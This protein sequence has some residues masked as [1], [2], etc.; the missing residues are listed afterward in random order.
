MSITV[1]IDFIATPYPDPI[2]GYPRLWPLVMVPCRGAHVRPNIQIELDFWKLYSEEPAIYNPNTD[3]IKRLLCASPH[4][5]E[6]PEDMRFI[7]SKSEW[8]YIHDKTEIVRKNVGY[9]IV[10]RNGTAL[11]N[12]DS[13]IFFAVIKDRLEIKSVN[14]TMDTNVRKAILELYNKD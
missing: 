4:P 8:L 7:Q 14:V 2:N 11:F 6:D 3:K 1:S 10:D 12:L 9:E 13:L 5:W